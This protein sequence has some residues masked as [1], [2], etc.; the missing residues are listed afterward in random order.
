MVSVSSDIGTAHAHTN[1]NCTLILTLKVVTTSLTLSPVL[2]PAAYDC[3]VNAGGVSITSV[4][5]KQEFTG[6]VVSTPSV[7]PNGLTLVLHNIAAY[8]GLLL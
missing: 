6:T 3:S 1:F 7:T 5:W 2:M 4:T 8:G